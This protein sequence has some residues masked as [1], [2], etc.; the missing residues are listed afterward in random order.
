M[1]YRMFETEAEAMEH[2]HAK[3]IEMGCGRANDIT[4]YWYSWKETANGKWAVQ[5]PEG[6]ETEPVWKEENNETY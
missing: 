6:T 3:A 1:R 4:Q 2:S 5:C